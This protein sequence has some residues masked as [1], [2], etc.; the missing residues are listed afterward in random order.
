MENIFQSLDFLL[1]IFSLQS[2]SRSMCHLLSSTKTVRELFFPEINLNKILTSTNIQH[3]HCVRSIRRT[4]GDRI[5]FVITPTFQIHK[6]VQQMGFRRFKRGYKADRLAQIT[7][8]DNAGHKMRD[9]T[10]PYFPYQW[11]LVSNSI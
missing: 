10:D 3:S 5:D 11:Y 8:A 2:N 9:P 6:A 1:E 4:S 7:R